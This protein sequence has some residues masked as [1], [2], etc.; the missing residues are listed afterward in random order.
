M[1]THDERLEE[2]HPT[3]AKFSGVLAHEAFQES[4]VFTVALATYKV[5]NGRALTE[6]DYTDSKQYEWDFEDWQDNQR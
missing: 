5:E 6:A 4:T 2:P 1:R 3:L